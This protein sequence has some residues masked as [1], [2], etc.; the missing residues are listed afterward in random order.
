MWT[1]CFSR[2]PCTD[3]GTGVERDGDPPCW[4]LC[5]DRRLQGLWPGGSRTGTGFQ[6]HPPSLL[7]VLRWLGIWGLWSDSGILKKQVTW[8]SGQLNERLWKVTN[9]AS[10]VY[11][12]IYGTSVWWI[13]TWICFQVGSC[14]KGQGAMPLG[15]SW[16][17]VR[18]QATFCCDGTKRKK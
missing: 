15:N 17:A 12:H 18:T 6:R 16:K 14:G 5:A 8:I 4:H 10:F 13:C 9:G 1:P 11:F 2:S 3:F 7:L